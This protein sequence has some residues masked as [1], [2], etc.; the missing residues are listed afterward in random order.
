M[1][2]ALD[3]NSTVMC[4]HAGQAQPGSPSP[5]VTMA[6]QAAV[7]LSSSY[8]ISGCSLVPQAGGPCATALWVVGTTRVTSGG[9]PL[10]IDSGSAVCV[11]TGTGLQVSVVQ[12]KVQMT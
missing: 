5:R 11:P 6:N 9:T 12:Q 1:G 10:L 4:S 3:V 7:P 8:T 2:Y